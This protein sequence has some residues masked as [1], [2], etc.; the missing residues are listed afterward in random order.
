VE[1]P[2]DRVYLNCW[3][4]AKNNR[5]VEGVHY[6]IMFYGGRL[7]SHL[8][9]KDNDEDNER[10]EDF[11]SVRNLNRNT[12]IVFDSD[13]ATSRSH[14]NLTKKRLQQEFDDGH[15]FAWVTQ[16]REVENYL[17]DDKVEASVKA[18][19]PSAGH[20]VAKGKW[21]NLLIYKNNKGKSDITANKVKVA[22]HYVENN[23]A[24]LSV[25][26]LGKKIDELC[27]FISMV[28]GGEVSQ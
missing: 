20:L 18:V 8:T 9:A 21:A 24:D 23:A 3:I 5:L 27:S 12:V 4:Q 22:R 25:L 26:D 7:F 19:H 16:G 1:G 10:L 11:I 6:S 17:D 28:N 13:K 2:S 14:L 15:G